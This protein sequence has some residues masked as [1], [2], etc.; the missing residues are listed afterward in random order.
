MKRLKDNQN[1]NKKGTKER[2]QGLKK[3]EHDFKKEHLLIRFKRGSLVA[4]SISEPWIKPFSRHRQHIPKSKRAEFSVLSQWW[5]TPKRR[6]AV[7]ASKR[8]GSL[9]SA[10]LKRTERREPE[11]ST[12]AFWLCRLK[13]CRLQAFPQWSYF[14]R[15]ST[16]NRTRG[17][18]VLGS[19]VSL[20]KAHVSCREHFRVFRSPCS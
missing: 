9:S 14:L 10:G 3:K 18:S 12:P 6:R 19:T 1:E 15:A 4:S 8:V 20:W 16:R 2:P 17:L 13:E 11:D 5:T 7:L